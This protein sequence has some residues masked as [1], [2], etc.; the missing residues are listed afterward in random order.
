MQEKEITRAILDNFSKD[1]ASSTESEEIIDSYDDSI[2][3]DQRIVL[4]GQFN[5]I[6]GSC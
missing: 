6:H 5:G 1:E 4:R 2:S 3:I